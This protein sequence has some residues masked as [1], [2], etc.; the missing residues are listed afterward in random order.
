MSE[1]SNSDRRKGIIPWASP[2][3]ASDIVIGVDESTTESW[4]VIVVTGGR[5]PVVATVVR[6]EYSLKSLDRSG[7]GSA[8]QS[9]TPFPMKRGRGR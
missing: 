8:I 2:A 5:K 3:P 1:I 9:W 6:D 4:S 7:M